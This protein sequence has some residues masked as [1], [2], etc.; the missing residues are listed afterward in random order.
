MYLEIKKHLSR[1]PGGAVA[2][3]SGLAAKPECAL[4]ER[5]FP[6]I[7]EPAQ[8]PEALNPLKSRESNLESLQE[9]VLSP[10][11]LSLK[12]LILFKYKT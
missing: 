1:M 2:S 9:Q 3:R 5:S 6:D 10:P 4:Q 7:H 8:E 12:L 11:E